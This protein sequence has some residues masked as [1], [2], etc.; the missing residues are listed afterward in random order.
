MYL[1]IPPEGDR[2]E[3]VRPA[4]ET[5]R[6]DTMAYKVSKTMM[7]ARIVMAAYEQRN[8]PHFHI[9]DFVEEQDMIFLPIGPVVTPEWR[10]GLDES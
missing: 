2:V 6:M 8:N 9:V 4:Q 1:D 7:E 5:E 3:L 10:V